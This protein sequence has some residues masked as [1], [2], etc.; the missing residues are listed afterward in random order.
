MAVLAVKFVAE[1]NGNDSTGTGSEQAPYRT[2]NKAFSVAAPGTQ[3]RIRGGSYSEDEARLTTSGTAAD[4][5][6]VMAHEIGGAYEPVTM[7]GQNYTYPLGTAVAGGTNQ[8]GTWYDFN[9]KG[10][11]RID[12]S[13]VD[14]HHINFLNSR[15]AGLEI[16]SE[17]PRPSSGRPHHVTARDC[18]INGA[19]VN[20][21]VVDAVND[22]ICE[23]IRF[24]NGGNYAPFHRPTE[25]GHPGNHPGII[26]TQHCER[27]VIKDFFGYGNWGEGV[28]INKDSFDFVLDGFVAGSNMSGNIY[29]HRCRNGIVRNCISFTSDIDPYPAQ[30][31]GAGIYLDNEDLKANDY[32][33]LMDIGNVILY[34][35]LSINDRIGFSIRNGDNGLHPFE[36]VRF[37]NNHIVRPTEVGFKILGKAKFIG[38]NDFA[39]NLVQMGNVANA[40]PLQLVSPESNKFTYRYNGWSVA[41]TWPAGVTHSNDV[42]GN[43]RLINPNALISANVYDLENYKLRTTAPASPAIGAGVDLSQ[44]FT[45]DR[46]GVTRTIWSIGFHEASGVTGPTVPVI[47]SFTAT[48]DS[49]GGGGGTTTLAWNVTGADTLTINQGVGSVSPVTS[50]STGVAVTTSKTFTLTA[51]N[52]AGSASEIVAVTVAATPPLPTINSFTATPSSL[53]VGGGSVVLAWNVTGATSL[54]INQGIGSVAPLTVGTLNL[55][56]NAT[57]GYTLTAT[58]AVGSVIA[59]AIVTVQEP[60]QTGQE[61]DMSLMAYTKT[62]RIRTY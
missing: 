52:A 42:I 57:T 9:Y 37:Y 16:Q 7:D 24:T 26:T 40:V 43:M 5:I 4:H 59:A 61:D 19:R 30:T 10:L 46:F 17:T 33:D 55:T 36:N 11:I 60:A 41:P 35:N 27:V 14:L 3:I 18:F 47:N 13:Y 44:Y 58:N 48:P 31:L 12:A 8:Y 51:T 34:N 22:V 39:N 2:V 32:Q 6:E 45:E 28:I 49:F 54:S 53:G 38:T 21:L 25:Q 56:V 50:G 29:L 1:S 62:K 20:I 15:G 23:R